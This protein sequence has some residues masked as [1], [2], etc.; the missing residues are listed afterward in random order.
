MNWMKEVESNQ[1]LNKEIQFFYNTYGISGL[2]Q[3]IKLYTD[4]QQKYICKTKTSMA[5]IYIKDIYYLK[6]QKHN[7]SVYTAQG[8][9]RKYGTLNGELKTLAPYG[10]MK[11]SQSFVVSLSKVKS[12]DHNDII[13]TNGSRIH[14]SKNY[15]QS[16]ILK[17]YG[18]EN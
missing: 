17:F 15:I 13:L 3:A 7:I 9:Y 16:I 14:V 2:K 11:C 6:I 10:F 1:K 5:V 4:M 12:I 18:K 8:V